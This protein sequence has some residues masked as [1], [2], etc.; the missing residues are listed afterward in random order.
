MNSMEH[1]FVKREY[2]PSIKEFLQYISDN[3]HKNFP[4]IAEVCD[5]YYVM[6]YVQGNTLEDIVNS[7]VLP[8]EEARGYILQLIDAVSIMHKWGI[9]HRDIKPENIIITADGTVKLIDF[10][11]SRKIITDKN[12]DTQLL[13]TAGYA[14]PEQFGFTQTDERSDIYAIGIVYNYMLTGKFPIE[15]LADGQ[16]GKII[17]KCTKIDKANR[18]KNIKLLRKDISKGVFTS[19]N[20]LDIIPGFR[21]RNLFKMIFASLCYICGITVI[22]AA[23]VFE[24]MRREE[25]PEVLL[26][27]LILGGYLFVFFSLIT[28]FVGM[29]DRIKLP[30]KGK[31]KKKVLLIAVWYIV[32]MFFSGGILA[33]IKYSV[34]EHPVNLFVTA[35]CYMIYSFIEAIFIGMQ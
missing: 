13:G 28:N 17:A 12:R 1:T 34:F 23:P 10:D 24:E 21:T 9:V 14:A 29:V 3:P 8:K 31:R 7:C 26:G 35:I 11:I 4:V 30:I 16:E 20:L 6:E 27:I 19:Y 22:M 32:G 2:N 15:Q 5:D 25:I 33:D 18:Y